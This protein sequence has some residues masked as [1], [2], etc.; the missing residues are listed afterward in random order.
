[1][2]SMS[3]P[4][5]SDP[6]RASASLA[7]YTRSA[8]RR[9]YLVTAGVLLGLVAG[10]LLLPRILP[11]NAKYLASVQM[12]VRSVNLSDAGDRQVDRGA[13]PVLVP[14]V[15]AVQA[16]ISDLGP[17][18]A[19]LKPLRGQP[20]AQWV[21]RLN[22][23]LQAAPIPGTT[24][25]T[26]SYADDDP[27]L[28]ERVLT[29]YAETYATRRNSRYNK[30]L[31]VIRMPRVRQIQGLTQLVQRLSQQANA[32]RS[33][34]P[35]GTASPGT[36]AQLSFN[37]TLL[38]NKQA[39]LDDIDKRAALLGTP[40]TLNEPINVEPQSNPAGRGVALA[41]G[42]LLG[43]L[44]GIG[45]AFVA[46]A[47]AP[48]VLS[49]DDVESATDLT[50]IADVPHLPRRQRR[51]GV[52]VLERPFSPT[53]E[54]YR[55]LVGALERRGL[56][57]SVKVLAILSAD[58]HEGKSTVAVNLAHVLARL[59]RNVVLVSSDLRRPGIEKLLELPE[60][61]GLAGYLEG[62]RNDLASLFV[63]V[64]DNLVVL[65]AGASKSNPADLLATKQVGAMLKLLRATGMI[66]I[67]DTP[68]S[69]W[70][71]DAISLAGAADASLLVVKSGRASTKSIREVAEG[72]RREGLRTLGSILLG[73]KTS[74]L[75]RLVRYGHYA[76]QE[77]Y[78]DSIT[79][80]VR[81]APTSQVEGN[82]APS[83]LPMPLRQNGERPGE[84]E[85][86]RPGSRQALRGAPPG[87]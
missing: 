12:D 49:A 9:K 58:A 4:T 29:R 18:A 71:A 34:S 2:S 86:G 77:S 25:F 32:E 10:L 51:K 56:G 69:R 61:D 41:I 42:L 7:D 52:A 19:R 13:T 38:T 72:L 31:T 30:Q 36:E 64:S 8:W 70:S 22:A 20:K 48:K 57:T 28:A 85:G 59:G 26:V 1:M 55:R 27:V 50:V 76:S 40:T 14:D 35:N 75:T 87:R 33:R 43:L 78:S 66:V 68:P 73:S 15:Q 80:R 83:G 47:Y 81:S 3:G 63:S 39:E 54:G 37:T 45:A 60:S 84:A 24:Q 79:A 6:N 46:E 16:V 23:A 21:S 74:K 62:E 5:T 53:A 44:G 17:A 82:R 65:P 67:L 11:S